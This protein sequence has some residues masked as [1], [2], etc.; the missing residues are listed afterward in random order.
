MR[1]RRS[2]DRAPAAPPEH[3]VP[4]VIEP[5]PADMREWAEEL[6]AHREI[7][8]LRFFEELEYP[9]VAKHLDVTEHAARQRVY[10]AMQ[11]LRALVRESR[12]R[13]T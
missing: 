1:T 13:P 7:L 11:A 5:P 6:V 8:V 4:A 10:R 3:L 9:A 2:T 12:L